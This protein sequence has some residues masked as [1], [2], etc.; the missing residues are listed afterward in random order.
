M[1]QQRH[2]SYFY[3]SS[4]I[5]F[6]RHY[7]LNHA[8]QCMFNESL[9]IL[10]ALLFVKYTIPLHQLLSSV[11]T[12]DLITFLMFSLVV[13]NV[14]CI[15]FNF[16]LANWQYVILFIWLLISN[17][18][19]AAV[20][21]RKHYQLCLLKSFF[22]SIDAAVLLHNCFWH[23]VIKF[24]FIIKYLLCFTILLIWTCLYFLQT[25]TRALWPWI[26]KLPLLF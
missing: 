21:Y 12:D 13:D 3:F 23:R 20:H 8:F 24:W 17:V 6:S 18:S 5:L 15:L 9:K 14:G 2:A 19:S 4:F 11:W 26:Y 10:W 7:F 25:F 22:E 16:L 1:I